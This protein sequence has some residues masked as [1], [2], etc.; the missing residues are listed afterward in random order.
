MVKKPSGNFD[1][2]SYI[3]HIFHNPGFAIS[4]YT[5]P[6]SLDTAPIHRRGDLTSSSGYGHGLGR[7]VGLRSSKLSFK[8]IHI[9]L[10][11]ESR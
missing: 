4:R 8:E 11:A 10:I 1:I 2:D 5:F 7:F 3:V 6:I 9:F